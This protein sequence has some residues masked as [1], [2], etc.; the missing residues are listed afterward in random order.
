MGRGVPPGEGGAWA[1][2]RVI[3][4]DKFTFVGNPPQT[5]SSVLVPYLRTVTACHLRG[6]GA[7]KNPSLSTEITSSDA[8]SCSPSLSLSD[9]RRTNRCALPDNRRIC[10]LHSDECE[11]EVTAV[12]VNRKNTEDSADKRS[13]MEGPG[14]WIEGRVGGCGGWGS[15]GRVELA[16]RF[17]QKTRKFSPPTP[18][19]PTPPPP[20]PPPTDTNET[21]Q[22]NSSSTCQ[23]RFSS[24]P[25]HQP[26]PRRR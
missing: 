23:K 22:I 8:P 7:K 13:S 21:L 20:A 10:A 25:P 14:R 12:D 15:V 4:G 18:L 11:S 9:G 26:G 24:R 17:F 2:S 6:R 16:C 3:F 19:P 1:S 5:T